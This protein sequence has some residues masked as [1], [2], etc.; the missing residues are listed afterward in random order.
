MKLPRRVLLGPG[1]LAITLLL[2]LIILASTQTALV[3]EAT[4]GRNTTTADG[5]SPSI[6]GGYAPVSGNGIGVAPAANQVTTPTAL[7]NDGSFENLPSAWQ[8]QDNTGCLPWI[9]DW[10]AVIGVVAYHGARYF[11]AGG[12]CGPQG[13]TPAPNSNSVEQQSIAVPPAETTL[14]FWYYAERLD[15][16]DVDGRDFAYVEVNGIQ[17]WEL[18]MVQANNTNGWVNAAVDLSTYAGQSVHL[19]LGAINDP[20]GGVGNVY[21]D[22]IEFREPAPL[23]SFISPEAGGVLTYTNPTG[24]P[25][26]ITVPPGAITDTIALVYTPRGGPG[27]PLGNLQFANR[28][29]DLDGQDNLLYLPS[30]FN[31]LAIG[32]RPA[33][34]AAGN[35]AG[36]QLAA[37]IAG[38]YTF[39]KPIDI[40]ITYS[41]A[42]VPGAES[43]L[44]LYYW[45]GSQW[46]DAVS[47]CLPPTGYMI[48]ETLNTMALS[49]CHLSRFSMVGAG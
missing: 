26:I 24:L 21:F 48:N 11:W 23:V 31:A 7:I 9:G 20:V 39:L 4:P 14:S 10:S 37:P 19:K 34:A 29:F 35:S 40:V 6:S 46:Q 49:I 2:T 5:R 13:Q 43:D 41:D 44:R 45:T 3:Q 36:A 32:A 27:H 8:E 12:A 30:L 16:D 1:L 18:N 47:T 33:A 42:D 17:V 25:T 38:S 15:L 28:A 22:F